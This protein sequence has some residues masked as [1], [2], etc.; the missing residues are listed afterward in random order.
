MINRNRCN[1]S[2]IRFIDIFTNWLHQIL[3]PQLMNIQGPDGKKIISRPRIFSN[4][5]RL[6]R[7]HLTAI[8]A[9]NLIAIILFRVMA[10]RDHNSGIC[11]QMTD[12]K[13]QLWCWP[14]LIKDITLNA[15]SAE[16]ACALVGKFLTHIPRIV[17][18]SDTPSLSFVSQGIH[19]PCQTFSRL[20]DGINIHAADPG[21]KH[22]AHA[23]SPKCHWFRKRFFF[24]CFIVCHFLKVSF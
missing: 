6:F 22:T 16:N 4:L 23:G 19:E 13:T 21:T 7:R 11:L 8:R 10:S 5:V 9:I 2:I 14:Q 1:F 24:G 3:G 12:G 20:P 15:M 18:N 17:T